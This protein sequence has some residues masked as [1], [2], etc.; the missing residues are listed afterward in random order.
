[1]QKYEIFISGLVP[2]LHE[3]RVHVGRQ[4]A[5]GGAGGR[6]AVSRLYQVLGKQI[7][8]SAYPPLGTIL[9]PIKCVFLEEGRIPPRVKK[10]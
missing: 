1:M 5:A 10:N 4:G 2:G 8:R 9:V 7:Y 3:L 6:G